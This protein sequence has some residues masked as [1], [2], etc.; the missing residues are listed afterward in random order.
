MAGG[1]D[2]VLAPGAEGMLHETVL[3]RVIRD[4]GEDAAWREPVAQVGKRPLETNDLLVDGD[5]HCLEESRERG[6]TGA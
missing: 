5:A 2:A 6:G 1:T 4:D 3:T